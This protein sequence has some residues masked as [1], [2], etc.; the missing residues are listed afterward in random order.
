[1]LFDVIVGG[2][3]KNSVSNSYYMEIELIF[4]YWFVSYSLS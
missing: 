2:I 1:M 4:V 3:L